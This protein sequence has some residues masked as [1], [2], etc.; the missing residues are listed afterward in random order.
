MEQC[1]PSNTVKILWTSGIQA[2]LLKYYVIQAT[3]LKYYGIQATLLKHYG[4]VV[5]KQQC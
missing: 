1:Y 5:T 4:R 3:L 2:T